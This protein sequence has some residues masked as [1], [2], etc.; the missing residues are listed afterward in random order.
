MPGVELSEALRFELDETRVADPLDE[1]DLRGA[2]CA[3][4][5]NA[6]TPRVMTSGCAFIQNRSTS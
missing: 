5:R 4:L 6:A 3:A 1:S 2:G